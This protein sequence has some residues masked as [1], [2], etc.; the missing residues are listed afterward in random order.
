MADALGKKNIPEKRC[1]ALKMLNFWHAYYVPSLCKR[2]GRGW[3]GDSPSFSP[4]ILEDEGA[5][6]VGG[7]MTC[8]TCRRGARGRHQG[9]FF[10][11]HR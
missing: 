8:V 1:S 5:G 2:E 3:V 4:D 9:F 11:L 10:V 6:W 7:G